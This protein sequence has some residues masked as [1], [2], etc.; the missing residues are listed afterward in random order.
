MGDAMNCRHLI[1]GILI[2]A[3]FVAATGMEKQLARVR[4]GMKPDEITT[5]LGSPTA[6]LIAQPPLSTGPSAPAPTSP[7]PQFGP[8]SGAGNAAAS[9][10]DNTLVFL[11]KDQ[12]IELGSNTTIST[13]LDIVPGALPVWAYTIRVARLELNQQ[14]L[15]YRINDTYSLGIVI[16]GEGNE[17][18]VTDAIACSLK[19]LTTWPS[20]PKRTFSRTDPYF[21][22]MFYFK[23][24]AKNAQ[25]LKSAKSKNDLMLTAGTS[26]AIKIG[27]NVAE[28]LKAH[29][30]PTYCIPFTTEAAAIVTFDPKSPQPKVTGA[31]G[32]NSG[33]GSAEFSTGATGTLRASFANNCVLLYP[34]EGLALTLMNFVVVR[35]Q[36]G[37][38]MRRPSMQ[39]FVPDNGGTPTGSPAAI[40]Q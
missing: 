1:L 23:Y 27:S 11:Y 26:K 10:P 25:I 5:L 38:E 32:G 2:L 14:E 13:G 28:V 18:H 15:F 29:G 16:S 36:I 35:I 30:W 17:A 31:Q 33:G 40:R 8:V 19:P 7:Q 12:E 9:T 20:D 22:D 34:D 4:L 24:A 39:K 37:Q 21:Q 3:A 6:V